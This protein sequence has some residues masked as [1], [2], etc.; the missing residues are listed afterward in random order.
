MK[1][2]AQTLRFKFFILFGL[3]FISISILWHQN[4]TL[5][6]SQQDQRLNH[7]IALFLNSVI[8]NF[9]IR[10]TLST[11]KLIEQF[12]YTI[13]QKIPPNSIILS[14]Y[15]SGDL[16]IVI[17]RTHSNQGFMLKYQNHR[18]IAKKFLETINWDK[19]NSKILLIFLI[20]II[21]ILAI[22]VATIIIPIENLNIAI[23]NFMAGKEFLIQT[24]RKDEIGDLINV[25]NK[26]AT[27]IQAMM[28]SRELILRNIGHEL[29][30]PIAKI[31][32]IIAII[33][34]NENIN[35]ISMYAD[36]LQH[37]SENML[38]FERINSRNLRIDKKQFESETLLFEALN[39]FQDEEKYIQLDIKNSAKVK[40][41]FRLLTVVISN[42]IHNSL[43]YSTDKYTYIALNNNII[44]VKNKGYKLSKNFEYYLRPFYRDSTHQSLSGYGLGLSIVKAILDIHN[45]ELIYDYHNGYHIFKVIL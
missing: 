36:Q 24:N 25:F 38:E 18:I 45:M 10:G 26:S 3:I 40:G 14:N 11:H 8:A 9:T 39:K 20:I 6:R 30:T 19:P 27:Q 29:R 15:K 23:K 44:E 42:L 4:N 32:L 37:I 22:I 7:S 5:V 2:N 34:K 41:D 16:N 12:G 31:K 13:I 21:I 33:E 35:K 28:K 17:F 43:K 1:L